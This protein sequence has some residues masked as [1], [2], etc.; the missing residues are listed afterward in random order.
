MRPVHPSISTVSGGVTARIGCSAF[1]RSVARPASLRAVM[2]TG[3]LGALIHGTEDGHGK[4]ARAISYLRP[5]PPGFAGTT[6]SR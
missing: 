1:A 5:T 4:I 2:G 3:L 6:A